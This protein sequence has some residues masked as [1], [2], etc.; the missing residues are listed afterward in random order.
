MEEKCDIG[1]VGLEGFPG[2]WEGTAVGSM[3]CSQEEKKPL[4]DIWECAANEDW[5]ERQDQMES[6]PG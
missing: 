2:Q 6:C 3:G 4:A 5:R 1:L